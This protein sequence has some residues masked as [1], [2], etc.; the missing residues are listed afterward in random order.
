MGKQQILFAIILYI[1]SISYVL[2]GIQYED[3]LVIIGNQAR[4]KITTSN[5]SSSSTYS[6]WREE[7]SFNNKGNNRIAEFEY[8]YS[9]TSTRT[10]SIGAEIN[11]K[12]LL[13]EV[14]G[15]IGGEL[16][17]SKTQS[18]T[19]KRTIPANKVGHAYI[20]DKVTTSI[21]RH[22]IQVQEKINNV[23]TNKD[24]PKTSISRVVTTTPEIKID[25]KDN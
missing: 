17:W 16:Q 8:S 3:I 5:P 11:A 7:G 2:A 12:F 20:R 4:R 1:L 22:Q 19:G 23:W 9:S 15:S 10:F 6:P 18:F 14:K 25:I 21:F 24:S 13:A